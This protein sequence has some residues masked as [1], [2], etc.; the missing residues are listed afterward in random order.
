MD[1]QHGMLYRKV[2]CGNLKAANSEG[3]KKRRLNRYEDTRREVQNNKIQRTVTS[4]CGDT[5]YG[6]IPE[7][8]S[9]QEPKVRRNVG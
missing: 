9:K 1:V 3:V 2:T 6:R 5:K 8:T 7:Q 4:S